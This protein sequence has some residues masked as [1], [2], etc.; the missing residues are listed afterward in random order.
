MEASP[1]QMKAAL[2]KYREVDSAYQLLA[3]KE[4]RRQYDS[5]KK[6]RQA[7]TD[8]IINDTITFSDMHHGN[9]SYYWWECRCGGLYQMDPPEVDKLITNTNQI[10]LECTSCSLHILV[11]I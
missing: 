10:I 1:I 3:D 4:R 7:T 5:E 6:S 8:M 9:D 2:E 11:L